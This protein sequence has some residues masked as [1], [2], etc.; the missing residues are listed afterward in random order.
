MRR[1]S[2]LA[3]IVG[4]V[5]AGAAAAHAKRPVG[6][7]GGI[8][9]TAR[10]DAGGF[11]VV[12][13]VPDGP[14]AR[15]G[16]RPGDII[17]AINGMPTAALTDADAGD[18]I[19]GTAGTTVEI[20]VS[21]KQGNHV[22]K[23]RLLR[24]AGALGEAVQLA[25]PTPAQGAAPAPPGGNLT[26]DP[27]PNTPQA[28]PPPVGGIGVLIVKYRGTLRV[29]KTLPNGSAARAGIQ[30]REIIQAINGAPTATMT[31]VD[32]A[33]LVQGPVGTNVDL[34]VSDE[35]GGH[36][37]RLRLCREALDTAAAAQA[38]APGGNLTSVQYQNMQQTIQGTVGG[39]G[40]M[41]LK[42]RGALR[43]RETVAD[44]PAARAGLRS[45]AI[46]QAINGAPTATLTEADAGKLLRGP[47]GTTVELDVSD[48]G[49]PNWYKIRLV[50]EAVVV[51]VYSRM[52][53]RGIGLLTI[54]GFTNQTPASVRQALDALAR[55]GA[56]CLVV[57]LR[58]TNLVQNVANQADVAGFFVGKAVPLWLERKLGENNATPVQSSQPRIWSQPV[59]V[60]VN[61]GTAQSSVLLA[62]ALRSAGRAWVVGRKTAGASTAQFFE[63]RDDGSA[64]RI[65]ITRFFSLRD[66]PISIEGITPDVPLDASLSA[67]DELARAAA[68]FDAPGGR[69]DVGAR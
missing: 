31:D 57:D 18:L 1:T 37:R 4:L 20:E 38:A 5:V 66:E 44:G 58:D 23:L 33:E 45:G 14:A 41:L 54:T 46:I 28:L 3:A 62:S 60:L 26:S 51:G 64:R 25:M 39:I 6:I 22:R 42:D 59:V 29:S 8:G 40:A 16:I 9:A 68:I 11:R 47:A 61:G 65:G 52:L 10:G 15:A 67:R 34:D 32:A 43:V 56:R 35:N 13:T 69:A 55:M 17:Q 12:M 63:K 21:D 2:A 53:D 27:L 50:R 7:P 19:R 24:V 36:W 49:A 48:E 30:S